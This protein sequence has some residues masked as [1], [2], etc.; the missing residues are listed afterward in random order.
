MSYILGVKEY[1]SVIQ[2]DGKILIISSS[3]DTTI[4]ITGINDL[5]H[6]NKEYE[7]SVIKT[8]DE[9]IID[10][11]IKPNVKSM[12]VQKAEKREKENKKLVS[13]V[14]SC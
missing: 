1:D 8:E 13:F 14:K 6:D 3:D 11:V 12:K 7:C 2:S 4:R 10:V 9:D 5:V